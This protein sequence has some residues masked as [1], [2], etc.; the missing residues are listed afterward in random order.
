M[1]VPRPLRGRHVMGPLVWKV[2]GTGVAAAAGI[3]ASKGVEALWRTSGRDIPKD[4]RNPASTSGGE[5][6]AFAALTAVA[7]AA[8]QVLASRKAA[9]YYQESA[10]HLPKALDAAK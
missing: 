1:M 5:A 9:R 6:V 3:V 8:A 4:P 10:G 2:L 7:V